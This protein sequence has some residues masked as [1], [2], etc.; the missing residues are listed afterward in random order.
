MP[1]MKTAL[2]RLGLLIGAGFM[3]WQIATGRAPESGLQTL[4]QHWQP[5]ANA[6]IMV[7]VVGGMGWL[8]GWLVGWALDWIRRR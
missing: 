7:V 6:A 1:R 2:S 4:N 3:L 8:I 5:G